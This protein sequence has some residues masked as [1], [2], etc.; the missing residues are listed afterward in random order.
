MIHTP[1]P[2]IKAFYDLAPLMSPQLLSPD[3]HPQ[4]LPRDI[5]GPPSCLPLLC[6]TPALLPSL[7]LSDSS[8]ALHLHEASQA[9]PAPAAPATVLASCCPFP[10][11]SLTPTLSDL[12][13]LCRPESIIHL[14]VPSAPRRAEPKAERLHPFQSLG[15][16]SLFMAHMVLNAWG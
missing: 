11:G 10:S 7:S 5:S 16:H 14:R 1:Q 13:A 12:G 15:S 6:F 3:P 9:P 8:L 2:G 4:L